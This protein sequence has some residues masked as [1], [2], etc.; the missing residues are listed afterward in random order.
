MS[1]N[2]LNADGKEVY[3]NIQGCYIAIGEDQFP[4][5]ELLP[6]ILH[7]IRGGLFGHAPAKPRMP[8]HSFKFLY[9]QPKELE[10]IE[11]FIAKVKELERTSSPRG[12]SGNIGF[13][14]TSK[15]PV[16]FF[17]VLRGV[18]R[19][20]PEL[21]RAW[22][23]NIAMA[24][25]DEARRSNCRDSIKKIHEVANRAANNFLNLLMQNNFL[26][27]SKGMSQAKQ[28]E[29]AEDERIFMLMNKK[30]R[31]KTKCPFPKPKCHERKKNV[32]KRKIR[33]T[34]R[35]PHGRQS[36]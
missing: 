3:T 27:L 10:A 32:R 6:V 7:Y 23:D 36:R 14:P 24:Y 4:F 12:N 26:D 18:F 17:H 20:D 33:N 5:S 29:I 21:H 11:Q 2:I 35:K 30:A 28:I 22:K 1:N 25:F 13:E 31:K 19:A 9:I 16:N 34:G 8:G 15:L